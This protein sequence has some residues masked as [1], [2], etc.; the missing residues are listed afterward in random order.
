MWISMLNSSGDS[1]IENFIIIIILHT[2]KV[3]SFA[4]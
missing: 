3:S 2:S 1:I 4:E